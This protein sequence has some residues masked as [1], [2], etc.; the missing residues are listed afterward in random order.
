[1]NFF[2][3][4]N[5]TALISNEIIE[6]NRYDLSLNGQ[7]VLFG[8]A[9]SIDHTIS[10]FPEIGID[11]NGL[12]KFLDIE[13]RN[14]RYTVIRDALF[15][16]T[17]HPLQMKASEKKWSSIPWMSVKY[18]ADVSNFITIKFH[19]DAKPFL[20]ALRE[21]T[22]IK[23]HYI[24]SLSSTYA[25]WLYPMFK[26]IETKYHGKQEISIQRLKEFTFTDNPKEHPAYNTAKSATNNFMRKILGVSIDQKTKE[27]ITLPNGPLAEINEKTDI[28]VSV[29]AIIKTG[30]KYTSVVFYVANKAEG[31]KNMKKASKKEY[32]NEIPSGNM[33]EF[34]TPQ[35]DMYENWR[36]YNEGAKA[37][38]EKEISF[39]EYCDKCGYYIKN[40]GFVYKKDT[41]EE[42]E[43]KLK[44]RK[45]SENKRSYK[46]KTLF[47]IL[48]KIKEN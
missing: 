16:I 31:E 47:D 45:E 1:M 29:T 39:Q 35:K 14:D 32:V 17:E 22:K 28:V 44:Q 41:K 23:G 11:I 36:R 30:Q 9:Q 12:F 48:D 2:P 13:H 42:Y 6:R 33:A 7:K 46:E 37:A 5:R 18:D 20:L 43:R 3:T 34:R 40:D 19:E 21:Y 8:L 4:K 24:S 25:T 15:N 26:M 10:L 27:I 38:K